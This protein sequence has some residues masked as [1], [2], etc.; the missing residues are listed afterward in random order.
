MGIVAALTGWEK[1]LPNY[2]TYPYPKFD[3]VPLYYLQHGN[4][5]VIKINGESYNLEINKP[6]RSKL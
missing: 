3:Q 2:N 6:S 4:M 5:L 1:V